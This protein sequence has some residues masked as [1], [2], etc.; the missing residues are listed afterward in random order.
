M[1]K[2]GRFNPP[3]LAKKVSFLS[4]EPT[5]EPFRVNFRTE[6][7]E[8]LTSC[9]PKL[10]LAPRR[11][12]QALKPLGS[13]KKRASGRCTLGT[14]KLKPAVKKI[15]AKLAAAARSKPPSIPP[16]RFKAPTPH[17][18]Y[19]NYESFRAA[20]LTAE[21]RRREKHLPKAT[22]TREE[23]VSFVKDIRESERIVKLLAGEPKRKL[24]S[25]KPKE[26]TKPPSAEQQKLD[27]YNAKYPGYFSTTKFE[28]LSS[29]EKEELL[30]AYADFIIPFFWEVTYGRKE[31][32]TQ[33]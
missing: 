2:S 27:E 10:K 21:K 1:I 28:S 22:L 5:K 9:T 26:K 15:A 6:R 11:T 8:L 23:A 20:H 30:G 13:I 16:R 4:P 7:G 25:A 18:Y 14:S 33:T 3:K 17:T 29:N 24:P 31:N 19:P 32:A 12:Y